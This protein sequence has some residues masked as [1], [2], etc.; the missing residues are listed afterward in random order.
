MSRPRTTVTPESAAEDRRQLE[1][2]QAIVRDA[3]NADIDRARQECPREDAEREAH[4]QV[5]AMHRHML[6]AMFGDGVLAHTVAAAP[7]TGSLAERLASPPA[8]RVL[9]KLQREEALLS[10]DATVHAMQNCSHGTYGYAVLYLEWQG[11]MKRQ[12]VETGPFPQDREV[13]FTLTPAGIRA[14]DE[15]LRVKIEGGSQ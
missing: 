6:Q 8:G 11:L 14:R 12:V 7:A 4:R 2:W 13:R 15:L 1:A 5:E 10:G 3:A 9:L